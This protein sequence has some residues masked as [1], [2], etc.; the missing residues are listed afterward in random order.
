MDNLDFVQVAKIKV[1][2]VGGGGCNA[3][4]RMA[5]DGV[6]GVDFYVC[7]T[8]CVGLSGIPALQKSYILIF[9]LADWMGV[10]YNNFVNF[11]FSNRQKAVRSL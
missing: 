8:L 10:I 5:N 1:I 4:S 7:N 11:L 2:G 9:N 6:K 3:V